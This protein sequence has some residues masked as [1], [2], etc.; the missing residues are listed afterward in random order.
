MSPEVA[1]G[2]PTADLLRDRLE[3]AHAW[4]RGMVNPR[5]GL[6]EYLYHPASDSFARERAPIRDIASVWDVELLDEV[7]GRHDMDALV[8]T[9]LSHFEGWL[10]RREIGLVLSAE[11]LGEPSSIAHS[12]FLILALLHAPPPRDLV[13]VAR[14]ADAIV[15]RQRPDGSYRIHFDDLPDSGEELYGGEAM[16]ALAETHAQVRDGRFLESVARAAA[17]YDQRYFREGRVADDILVF[18]ANW[19][20]QA[21]RCL[22]QQAPDAGVKAQ[23]AAYLLAVHERIGARGFYDDVT[24]HPA[25][26]SAVE[27]ACAMEGLAD[28]WVVLRASEGGVPAEWNDWICTALAYLVR[29]Q[30]TDDGAGRERGGFGF[31]LG[32]R[33]QRVDVTGHAVNAFIKVLRSGVEC[34]ARDHAR[35][36]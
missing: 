36:E 27:V 31:A 12:A 14:L 25:A 15:A 24:R 9:S 3:L 18:F 29:L 7:L 13:R 21:C 30:C 5:T 33:T 22:H 35:A 19:Q 17:F 20:S 28:A 23:V 16:L 26:Q 11:R 6:L 1:S 2:R 4:Y 10:E 32:E 34:R 8:R